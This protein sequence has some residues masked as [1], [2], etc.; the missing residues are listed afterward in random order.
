MRR[1]RTLSTTLSVGRRAQKVNS[2]SPGAEKLP[3]S[4]MG[5]IRTLQKGNGDEPRKIDGRHMVDK[6][7]P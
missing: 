4:R 5:R 6:Q 3:S 2:S 1:S 7:A